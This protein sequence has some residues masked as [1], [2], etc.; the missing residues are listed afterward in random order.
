MHLLPRMGSDQRLAPNVMLERMTRGRT[1][2]IIGAAYVYAGLL[3]AGPWIFTMVGLFGLSMIGCTNDCDQLVI[4]RSIVIYNSLFSFVV[5]TPL[6]FF[7]GR[8]ISD[9][10][11]L[12]QPSVVPQTFLVLLGIFFA[13]TATAAVPFYLVA[14]RL[15]GAVAVAAIQDAFLIG[16]SWLL[17]PFLGAYRA[18]TAILAGFGMIA[19][20]LLLQGVVLRAPDAAGLLFGFNA[21]FAIGDTI[22]LYALVRRFSTQSGSRPSLAVGTR[23]ELPVAG[24]AYAVGIWADKVVMWFGAP[25]G[26]L[27]VAGVLRTMPSY[28]TAMFWA[29]MS[30]IPVV[31]VAFVHVET[32]FTEIFQRFYTRIE[33]KASLRELKGSIHKLRLCVISGIVTLFIALSVVAAMMIL[34]SF[35]FM[36]SLGLRPSYMS[37]LRLALM[38]MTFHTNSMFCFFFLLYFDLRRR[39]LLVVSIYAIL[40]PVMTALFLCL[41]QVFYGY[42]AMLAAAITFLLAFAILV[43]ELPWLLYHAF[44]TNN[45]SVRTVNV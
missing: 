19:V 29:Q 38:A 40:N 18:Q 22:L 2:S 7:A 34:S 9:A 3:V 42:G 33:E 17:I 12:D 26:T 16:L 44:I 11:Y 25:I 27:T 39:A 30:S 45:T 14:A 28:D 37:I 10:L 1:L 8:F 4:F 5:A 35:V 41:G 31:A 36:A 32:D 24:L 6:G 43:R 15:D 21:A 20:S 23:W 13:L